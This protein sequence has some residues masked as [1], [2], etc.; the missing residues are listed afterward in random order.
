MIALHFDFRSA[1]KDLNNV[2][3]ENN[4]AEEETNKKIFVNTLNSLKEI[5]TKNGAEL[6]KNYKDN[7]NVESLVN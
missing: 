2:G 3:D 1:L 5:Q 4:F 7:K 6:M